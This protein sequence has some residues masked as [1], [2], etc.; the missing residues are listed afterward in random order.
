[1]KQNI[2]IMKCSDV[3]YCPVYDPTQ[4]YTSTRVI[5]HE[6]N[7]KQIVDEINSSEGTNYHLMNIPPNF[8]K[9]RDD[10]LELKRKKRHE[11]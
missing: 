11:L 5:K 8:E 2:L 6:K 10:F 1:M 7:I 3:T 4:G 9:N